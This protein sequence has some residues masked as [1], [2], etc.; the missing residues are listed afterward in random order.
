MYIK[1]NIK[2]LDRTLY[3]CYSLLAEAEK[4]YQDMASTGAWQGMSAEG[5]IAQVQETLRGL[6]ENPVFTQLGLPGLFINSV[7]SSTAIPL[8]VEFTVS[9]L[10]AVGVERLAVFG[11]LAAGSTAEGFLSYYLGR[12]GGKIFRFLKPKEDGKQESKGSVLLTKY[13][14]IA[15]AAA[16][17]I[18]V[19]GDII[20][21]IAGSKYYDLK[22]FSIVMAAGKTVKA[23]ALV[24]LVGLLATN[25][26]D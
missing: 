24:Y 4:G 8:P 1:T 21:M 9:A 17:W 11:V 5:I 19:F 7:L 10:L 2:F 20:H 3:I 22:T 26:L 15:I 14:W 12:S 18:P 23:L 13:G 25:L 16:P 6:S